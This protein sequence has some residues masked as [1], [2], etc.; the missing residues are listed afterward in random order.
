MARALAEKLAP[1]LGRFLPRQRW[2]AGHDAPSELT[3]TTLDAHDGDPV[4][5]WLLVEAI[6]GAGG[7]ATYQV[8]LGGRPTPSDA[9]FLQG[10]ERVTVGEVDGWV[11]YDALVDPELA[12]VV[13]GKVAPDE[14]AALARPLVVE[15]SNSSV[16]YDER[17]ILK[18]FRRVHPEANP[19][20]EIT[21]VLGE[22]GFPHVVPQLA[23]LRYNDADLA[24]VRQYLLGSID[25]WQLAHTSLRD[26]LNTPGPPDEAGGDFGPEAVT[27]GEV[28]AQLHL[29]LAEAYGTEPGAPK[30]WL[31]GF[32]AQLGRLPAP[33]AQVEVAGELRSMADLVDAAAV[34]SVLAGLVDVDDPGPSMR[35]HGD[36]HLGQVLLADAGWFVLDFEG[37]PVRPVAERVVSSSPLRDVAGMFRSFHYAARTG[38]AERGRDVDRE[39]EGFADQWESRAVD[40]FWHGYQSVEG[41]D[42]LLPASPAD[43]GSLL[44]AFELDK[45]VYEVLYELS[46]RPDWVDIPASAVR[47]ALS[48]V[49]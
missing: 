32:R 30:S 8:V 48:L 18:L 29:A 41:I 1:L 2:Y 36:L 38:L 21:K 4:L 46:H 25:A 11:Y 45:A 5:L 14:S 20:V 22:R 28:T 16:V 23:E 37:E 49:A 12:L 31:D 39:L 40:G 33:S 7:S 15:Q 24:V 27:L 3:I 10:K 42:R 44:R 9:E 34:E 47:R 43:R 35:I 26:L 13:L 6:D 17:L 19:D